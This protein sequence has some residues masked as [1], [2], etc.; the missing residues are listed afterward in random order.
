MRH[1]T[2]AL[3]AVLLLSCLNCRSE[4]TDFPPALKINVPVRHAASAQGLKHFHDRIET[5]FCSRCESFIKTLS[6]QTGITG[7]FCHS[8]R[9]G[10]IIKC[11]KRLE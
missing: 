10:H 5:G 4:K 3:R 11:R 7:N 2:V 6:P 8:S 1:S 9:L